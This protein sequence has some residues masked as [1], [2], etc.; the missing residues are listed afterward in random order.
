MILDE[1]ETASSQNMV[2]SVINHPIE[3]RQSKL[4]IYNTPVRNTE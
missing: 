1:W 4:I 2:I 3:V